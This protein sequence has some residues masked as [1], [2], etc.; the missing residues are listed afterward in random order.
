MLKRILL[1]MSV[2]VVFSNTLC[3]QSY[4]LESFVKEYRTLHP[5]YSERIDKIIAFLKDNVEK[6]TG[7]KTI[8]RTESQ[9]GGFSSSQLEGHGYL[10]FSRPLIENFPNITNGMIFVKVRQPVYSYSAS[11]LSAAKDW[12]FYG[13]IMRVEE[14]EGVRLTD[15]FNLKNSFNSNGHFFEDFNVFDSS[16]KILNGS[17][18]LFVALDNNLQEELEEILLETIPRSQMPSLVETDGF[19]ERYSKY[20]KKKDA[21]NLMALTLGVSGN[22]NTSELVNLFFERMHQGI[23][24]EKSIS[25]RLFMEEIIMLI[26]GSS[27]NGEAVYLK[28]ITQLMREYEN[29]GKG[30]GYLLREANI[31]QKFKI[32]IEQRKAALVK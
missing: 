21:K 22:S 29:I 10:N 20:L 7:D 30:P 15:V 13:G 25:T 14:C 31:L 28:N 23:A 3:C 11:L 2:S 9:S 32:N 4:D 27:I 5:E 24:T 19:V 17:M 8:Y 26:E 6:K 16:H 18:F 12:S 1:L